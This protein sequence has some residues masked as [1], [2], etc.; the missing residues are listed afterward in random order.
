MQTLR[1][2]IDQL[3]INR[4]PGTPVQYVSNWRDTLP[5]GSM[6]HPGSIGKPDCVMCLGLGLVSA[7][8]PVRHPL[9][10]RLYACDCVEGGDAYRRVL[11]LS[12][13]SG[14]MPADRAL[15]W[16]S[17]FQNRAAHDT[18]KAIKGVLERGW[19]WCYLHGDPGPGKTLALKIAVAEL[20]RSGTPAVF[21]EWADLLEHL[22]KGFDEG[23]YERRVEDWRFVDTLAIDEFGRAKATD[24]VN[25]ATL[26]VLNR[27]YERA[28]VEHKGVTLFA[29][30]FSPS[31]HDEWMESR[32]MDKRFSVV[33]VVGPDM[34]ALMK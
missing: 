13:S 27:R 22:R 15:T 31:D 34:R 6:W 23:D 29:S 11:R 20:V 24:W 8:V 9:F 1:D 33:H 26:R 14:L 5:L 30:N 3:R 17:V 19:G 18:A 28:T 25:E 21:V 12:E 16:G 2:A 4:E 7:D 10:G 32:L